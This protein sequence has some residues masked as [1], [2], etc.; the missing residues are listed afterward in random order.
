MTGKPLVMITGASAGIGKA[1]AQAFSKAGH[2]LLLLARRVELLRD[3]DLPDA[4]CVAVDVRDRTAVE[5]AIAEGEAAHG[6]VDCQVNNAGIAP[7]AKLED[8]DPAEWREVIDINCVGVLNGMHAVMPAMKARRRGT[9]VNISSIAGRKSYPYHDVYCGTKFFV[10]A[11]S[12]GARRNMAPYDVRVIVV[13]PGL[14][15]TDIPGT[16]LNEEARAFWL[17]GKEKVGGG[18]AA[19]DVANTILFAYQMPQNVLLQELT[20]T[21]T[22]QDY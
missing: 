9:I 11:I 20:I 19:E 2:P 5:A 7:L 14:T 3:L 21:P 22:R 8:Q 16:M 12:E 4:V 10:H 15:E 1:T 17:S 18:I 13:S 6:P